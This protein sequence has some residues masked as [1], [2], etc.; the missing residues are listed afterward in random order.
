MKK[1]VAPDVFCIEER[2]EEVAA[3]GIME[4]GPSWLELLC[5]Q[6]VRLTLE[7]PEPLAEAPAV[8]AEG[9]LVLHHQPLRVS[10]ERQRSAQGAS[11]GPHESR[12]VLLSFPRS[13][14]LR[15]TRKA[16]Y[17]GLGPQSGRRTILR[18]KSPWRNR[19]QVETSQRE[20]AEAAA[21]AERSAEQRHVGVRDGH[22]QTSDP[23]STL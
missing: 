17:S 3:V 6:G 23:I 2:V 15:A 14:A 10:G 13:G 7:V 8:T 21:A 4:G 18:L 9:W 5:R 1:E 11:A 19:V 12:C 20:S 22:A 16:N